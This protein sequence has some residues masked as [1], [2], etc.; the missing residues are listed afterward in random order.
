MEARSA[1]R[2]VLWVWLSPKGWLHQGH[3]QYDRVIA[4]AEEES[5]PES[6]CWAGQ[7]SQRLQR[8]L[9]YGGGT[10]PRLAGFPGELG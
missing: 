2:K 1:L 4:K 7:G 9:G 10:G 3:W 8:A 6:G 5:H